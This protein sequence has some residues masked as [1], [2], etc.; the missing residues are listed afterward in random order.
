[1]EDGNGSKVSGEGSLF[2]LLVNEVASEEHSGLDGKSRLQNAW[3]YEGERKSG[4]QW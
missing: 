3:E 2:L 1:M 4:R